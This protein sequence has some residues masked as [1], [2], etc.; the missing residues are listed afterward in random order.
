MAAGM[1][2]LKEIEDHVNTEKYIKEL[3]KVCWEM[4]R[5]KGAMFDQENL[6]FTNMFVATGS[7]GS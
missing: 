6:G 1:A 4:F 2:M 7:G 5:A 3:S